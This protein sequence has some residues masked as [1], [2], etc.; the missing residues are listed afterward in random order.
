MLFHN[1]TCHTNSPLPQIYVNTRKLH[2]IT[3]PLVATSSILQILE[4][5]HYASDWEVYPNNTRGT[6]NDKTASPSTTFIHWMLLLPTSL[7]TCTLN[8]FK[9][10]PTSKAPYIDFF[11]RFPWNPISEGS[12]AYHACCLQILESFE[13][14]KLWPLGQITF[15]PL[16]HL[17]PRS[18][19]VHASR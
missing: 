12:G 17:S 6:L 2:N 7:S 3:C 15:W 4:C 11:V 8:V 13:I 18:L 9:S 14:S 1:V 16:R 19:N 10:K 5:I